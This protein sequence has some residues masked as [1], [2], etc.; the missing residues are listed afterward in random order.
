MRTKNNG[1]EIMRNIRKL[2]KNI[3]LYVLYYY[4]R[5]VI[6]SKYIEDN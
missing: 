2:T 1:K 4:T 3:K 6:Y 5:Y